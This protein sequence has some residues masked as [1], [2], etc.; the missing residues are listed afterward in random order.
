[1]TTLSASEPDNLDELLDKL[2]P[3]AR[4]RVLAALDGT[5]SP[6][7]EHWYPTRAHTDP[8]DGVPAVPPPNYPPDR[9]PYS[10]VARD[11][12]PP[13]KTHLPPSIRPARQPYPT[14]YVPIQEQ[15]VTHHK[16]NPTV[17][18]A[19]PAWAW[20]GALLWGAVLTPLVIVGLV[21]LWP[22]GF[23][24]AALS[25]A[26]LVFVTYRWVEHNVV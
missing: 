4:K 12:R 21:V 9:D 26:P 23:G 20:L 22:L 19:P 16:D 1:M 6:Q 11:E 18:D 24:L 3:A 2:A 14:R 25:A 5:D 7:Q 10:G 15:A 13:P 8:T 17:K